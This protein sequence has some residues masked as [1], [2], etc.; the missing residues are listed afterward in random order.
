MLWCLCGGQPVG[1]GSFFYHVGPKELLYWPSHLTS[2]HVHGFW[3]IPHQYAV[4]TILAE[5]SP[6]APDIKL[7]SAIILMLYRNPRRHYYFSSTVWE[8][9]SQQ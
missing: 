8:T 1:V 6:S 4:G 7:V 2:P 3:G 9:L 5:P